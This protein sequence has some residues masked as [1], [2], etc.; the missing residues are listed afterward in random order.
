MYTQPEI[1]ELTRR[2]ADDPRWQGI[3][4][5]Y[6]ASEVVRLRGSIRVDH[7]LARMG[8]ERLWKL[9]HEESFVRALGAFTGNQAV[10]QVQAGLRAIYLSGCGG[11]R[12]QQRAACTDQSLCPVDSVPPSS[13]ASTTRCAPTI[14][15]WRTG[16]VC[17][18]ARSSPTPRP[19]SA[20]RS[21]LELIKS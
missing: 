9:L 21:I 12:R 2:W 1:D 14:S 7:T 4:R 5:T 18:F 16:D 20:A 15:T 8:A 13:G 3:T 11:R 10:E 6:P 19:V 17:Y